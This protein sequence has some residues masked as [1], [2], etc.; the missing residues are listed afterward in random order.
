MAKQKIT[1]IIFDLD[2]T[3]ID[4]SARL[5]AQ[6]TAVSDT[7]GDSLEEKQRVIDAF[8]AANDAAQ[9]YLENDQSEYKGNIP[10][11][12]EEMG[13]LLGV[14]LSEEDTE[15]LAEAWTKAYEESQEAVELF[16]DVI[17]TLQTLK[18]SG[19]TLILASGNTEETRRALLENVGIDDYFSAIYAATDVG[20]QKQDLRFWEAVLEQLD[21]KPE[22]AIVVGNQ[23]NDDIMHPQTLGMA[24]VLVERPDMLKKNL[25]PD[26]TTPDHTLEDLALL[27]DLL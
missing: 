13:K 22:S 17:P 9:A 24:T 8:F 25:D 6:A 16:Q 10:W 20:Y 4:E 1:H 5:D 7:F 14:K 23:L 15:N 27:T 21:I 18:D 2:G 12:M 19:Y 3:L 26:D 11:Y